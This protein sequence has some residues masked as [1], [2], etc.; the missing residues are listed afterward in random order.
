VSPRTEI[1]SNIIRLITAAGILLAQ[2]ALLYSLSMTKVTSSL[3]LLDCPFARPWWQPEGYVVPDPS[4]CPH[5]VWSR[6]YTFNRA[7][8]LLGWILLTIALLTLIYFAAS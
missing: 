7:S 3:H 5:C 1:A 8:V 6:I 2:A 4:V